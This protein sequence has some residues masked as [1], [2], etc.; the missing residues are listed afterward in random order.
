MDALHVATEAAHWTLSRELALTITALPASG[1]GH[2]IAY[3]LDVQEAAGLAMALLASSRYGSRESRLYR[4]GAAALRLHDGCD[5]TITAERP[6]GWC[7]NRPRLTA[8]A[9]LHLG[10]LLGEYVRRFEAAA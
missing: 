6:D 7:R 1:R 10:A 5:L 9:A 8:D 3:R 2:A 4:N